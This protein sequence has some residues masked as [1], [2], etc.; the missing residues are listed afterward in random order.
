MQNGEIMRERYMKEKFIGIVVEIIITVLFTA[1]G[2]N[3][4]DIEKETSA[5]SISETEQ[6]YSLDLSKLHKYKNSL[7]CNIKNEKFMSWV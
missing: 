3:A 5:A 7:N 6:E 2:C 4:D 1:C